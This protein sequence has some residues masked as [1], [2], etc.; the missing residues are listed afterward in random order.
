MPY[1][2][3]LSHYSLTVMCNSI[4]EYISTSL[5]FNTLSH[6]RDVNDSTLWEIN[7]IIQFF[8]SQIADRE[9]RRMITP[10]PVRM[11]GD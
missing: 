5:D 7:K 11:G 8:I 6:K 4:P 9:C 2:N 10:M 1:Q 3:E